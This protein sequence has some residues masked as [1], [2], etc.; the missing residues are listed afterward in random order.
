MPI[1][2]V[3]DIVT[4][5]YQGD[6]ATSFYPQVLVLQESAARRKFPNEVPKMHGLNLNYMTDQELEY[7][8]SVMDP[9]Y[10]EKAAQ[11]DPN[12]RQQMSRIN[13]ISSIVPLDIQTPEN[14]YTRVIKD[15]VRRSDGYRLYFPNKMTSIRIVSK[16]ET[17][18]GEKQGIFHKYLGRFMK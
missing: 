14:F 2:R 17:L 10:G 6:E 4:F 3:G 11:K 8:W 15:F 12:L 18:T 13:A 7:L 1:Y 9:A 16:R 5:S